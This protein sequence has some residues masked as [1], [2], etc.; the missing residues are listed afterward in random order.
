[1]TKYL[2]S[3][4]GVKS[5]QIRSFFWSVFSCVW[6]ENG[7]LLHISPYSVRI[8]E[9]TDQKKLH[10]WT[11]FGVVSEKLRENLT[12]FHCMK[13]IR[14]RSYSGPHFPVFG[15]NTGKYGPEKTPYLRTFHA[16]WF[17][18]NKVKI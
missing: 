13:S 6:T 17:L 10:I 8:Q 15:L 16:V 2:K 9:N 4:P 12:Q 1:M 3:M 5:I 14:I 11:F 18:K 7:Y